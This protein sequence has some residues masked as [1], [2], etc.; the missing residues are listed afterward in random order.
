MSFQLNIHHAWQPREGRRGERARSRS[1]CCAVSGERGSQKKKKERSQSVFGQV[2]IV[3]DDETEIIE[4]LSEIVITDKLEHV[5]AVDVERSSSIAL[6]YNSSL[7]TSKKLEEAES[8]KKLRMEKRNRKR[9][10]VF[11]TSGA[12]TFLLMAATLVTASFLMSPTIEKIFGG[13]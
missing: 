5:S 2:E 3:E 10:T 13:L 7:S 8:K 12:M 11:V 6:S 9:A 1:V 4:N